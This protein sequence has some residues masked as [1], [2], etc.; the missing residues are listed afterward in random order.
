MAYTQSQSN[1]KTRFSHLKVYFGETEAIYKKMVPFNNEVTAF[2]TNLA[3]LD[4]LGEDKIIDT[5][6]DTEQKTAEKLSIA[7]KVALYCGNTKA[8]AITSGNKDLAAQMSYSK[9]AI[10]EMKDTEILGFVNNLV[11]TITPLLED[12]VFKTYG[13]TALLLGDLGTLATKFNGEIGHAGVIVHGGTVANDNIDATIK[14][15]HGNID[16]ME[17]LL[18][19]FQLLNPDFVTGFNLN[20]KTIELGVQHG[21]VIGKVTMEKTGAELEGIKVEIVGTLKNDV[22]NVVGDYGIIKVKPCTKIVEASGL[23]VVTQHKVHTFHRGRI[24]TLDFVMVSI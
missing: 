18:P 8:F 1:E 10:L 13:I 23:G 4:T 14:L 5:S 3:Y 21:G 6:G 16:M 2:G 7:T 12:I 20:A 22:T 9:S 24:E 11:K 19:N 15:I 17:L